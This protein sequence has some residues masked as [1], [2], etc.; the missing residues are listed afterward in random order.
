MPETVQNEEKHTPQRGCPIQYRRKAGT[1]GM[2]AG[3]QTKPGT[4]GG[5][6]ETIRN[7]EK[8]TPQRGCPRRYTREEGKAGI[9]T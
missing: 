6:P 4:R 2:K 3:T 7:G 8:D 9:Q 5:M 1:A